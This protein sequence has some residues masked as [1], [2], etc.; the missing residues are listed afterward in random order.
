MNMIKTVFLGLVFA[1][2][3][4]YFSACGDGVEQPEP[5]KIRIILV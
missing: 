1:L 5:P 3:F 4:E 2:A